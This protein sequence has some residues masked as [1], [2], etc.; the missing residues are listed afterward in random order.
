[1]IRG[2][3]IL[4]G[5]RGYSEGGD[6][7]RDVSRDDGARADRTPRPHRAPRQRA[8]SNPKKRS[9]FDANVSGEANTGSDMNK[10]AD[11]AVVINACP[12]IYNDVATNY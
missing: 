12:G 9:G 2:S 5:D 10:I 11:D 4:P 6:S 7:G 3:L 1:M 8:T